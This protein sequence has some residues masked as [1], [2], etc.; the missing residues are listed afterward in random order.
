SLLYGSDALGGVLYLNPE[1]FAQQNKNEGDIN[2]DYFSNTNGYSTNAGFKS[3]GKKLKYLVR[4]ALTS[5]ADYEG[6]DGYKV[7]NSRF[8]DYD[9]KTGL[10]YQHKK[11]KTELSYNYNKSNLRIPEEIGVLS[12]SREHLE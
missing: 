10:G 5:H 12:N 8:N 4:G 3:Y 9:I 1:K 6:E 2:F 7:T 11:L